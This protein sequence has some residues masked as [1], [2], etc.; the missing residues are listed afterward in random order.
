M[1]EALRLRGDRFHDL[2]MRM[3]DGGHGDPAGEVEHAPT[4]RREQPAPLPPIDLEP[5]VVTEDR[6][7]D[8][9]RSGFEVA[10]A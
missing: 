2:R 7:K 4:V 9:T 3:T 6:R 5:R 8:A 1:H 10:H